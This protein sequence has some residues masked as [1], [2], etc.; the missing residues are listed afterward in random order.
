MTTIAAKYRYGALGALG[1][2]ILSSLLAGCA[3]LTPLPRPATLHER[4]AA[5]PRTGLPLEGEVTVY[6]DEHQIPFIEAEHD[7]DAAFTLGL[8]HAHLRLGQM[9]ILRR[10]SQGRLAEMAGPA[11]VDADHGLRL[12]D[13][14]RAA[15]Q[16]AAAM[17]QATRDWVEAFVRGINH[18]QRNMTQAPHEYRVLGLDREPWTVADVLTLGRMAGA[19]VNWLVWV[20]LLKL[21]DRDDWPEIWARLIDKG[22]VSMPSFAATELSALEA[23]IAGLSRSG[24]NSLAVAPSRS[25]SG[26]ALMVNDPHIGIQLPSLWLLAGIESPSTHAVGLMFPGLPFFALGRN[27][28]IAWGGTNMRAASSE[29][30][31]VSRLP[32]ERI[33][34]RRETIKVRWWFDSEVRLRETP[35]GPIV[36]DAPFFKDNPGAPFAL[37]WTGHLPSD[38][39]SAMLAVNRA[40]NFAEFRAAFEGFAVPGENMLYADAAGNIGQVMAVHLPKRDGAPPNDVIVDPDANAEAWDDMRDVSDLPFSL[41]PDQG[42]LASANNRPTDTDI[43][44]SYFFSPDDRVGRM[45]ELV[46]D[47]PPLDLAAVQ[48]LQQDVYMPSAAELRQLFLGKLEEAGL[49]A[50]ARGMAKRAIETLRAWDGNYATQARGPVAFEAFRQ[51]FSAAFY[52]FTYGAEDWAAFASFGRIKSLMTEDI[53]RAAPEDLRPALERGLK[54]AAEA[55]GEFADWGAMH[56]LWLAHPLGALPLV[57]GRYRFV[58]E[59]IGGSN[60]TLMKT[61]HVLTATRHNARYGST[62]RH[63]SDMSDP[64]ANYFVLL[65][66]QDGW[67]NSSTFLDQLPLWLEGAYIRMPL[68]METVRQD[69]PHRTVLSP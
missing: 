43:Q 14:G 67:L 58:D 69:F 45:A 41:N 32:A 68:R 53:A 59:A 39:L 48:R 13:L 15:P 25:A 60:D 7:L 3:L 54:A 61:A 38:E 56:R 24:S 63:I 18:V 36:S 37:R 21:R 35:W 17:P 57:G 31:D 12:L 51:A 47:G 55:L 27:P 26:G 40:R 11:M 66:G 33:A 29:L 20:N 42:F 1:I 62:A 16:I 9:E 49:A 30:Y 65:G 64:D 2:V 50:S 19:D 10:I 44:I 5:V 4:L 52:A 8:V 28:W 23:L 6:W 46:R 22:T 34:E